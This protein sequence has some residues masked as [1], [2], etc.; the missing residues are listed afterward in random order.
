MRARFIALLI[1][2]GLFAQSAAVVRHAGMLVS[3]AL[4]ADSVSSL[5]RDILAAMC[6]PGE[7]ALGLPLAPSD[8]G[9]ASSTCPVCNGLATAFLLDAPDLAVSDVRPAVRLVLFPALDL[10]DKSERHIRPQSRGPPAV[11]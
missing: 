4:A 8:T 10:R 2:L 6:M 9:K 5:D 3:T 1:L 7:S 11:A